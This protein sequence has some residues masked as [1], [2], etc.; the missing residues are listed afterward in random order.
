MDLQAKAPISEPVSAVLAV[1]SRRIPV[2]QGAITKAEV[3]LEIALASA[4]EKMADPA[5]S[6][7]ARETLAR[8]AKLPGS[9]FEAG[10]LLVNVLDA[11]SSFDPCHTVLASRT[12]DTRVVRTPVRRIRPF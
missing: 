11:V 5:R 7:T 3:E 2:G 6:Q 4:P 9:R 12:A 10:Y 8:W 1:L